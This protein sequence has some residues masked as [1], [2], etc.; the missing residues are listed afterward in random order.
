MSLI[1]PL[2]LE[3]ILLYDLAGSLEIA[4]FIGIIL[5]SFICAKFNLSNKLSL[6]FLGLFTVIMAAIVPP[7][8]VLAIIITGLVS[9]FSLVKVIGR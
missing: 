1:A 9:Y 4:G 8:Y 6:V 7:L 3:H 2:D 5:I